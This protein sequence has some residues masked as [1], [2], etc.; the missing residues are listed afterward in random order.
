MGNGGKSAVL[1]TLLGYQSIS[2]ACL[3]DDNIQVLCELVSFSGLA[4]LTCRL[5]D[6]RRGAEGA[7]GTSVSIGLLF[8]SFCRIVESFW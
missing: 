3:L 7:S 1:Q 6:V 8:V 5:K 2:R 4:L